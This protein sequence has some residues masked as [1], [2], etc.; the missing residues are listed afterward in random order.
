MGSNPAEDL[1][2][3]LDRNPGSTSMPGD[4]LSRPAFHHQLN[5]A[6]AATNRDHAPI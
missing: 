1:S 3:P 5:D 4:Q 2:S 6:L